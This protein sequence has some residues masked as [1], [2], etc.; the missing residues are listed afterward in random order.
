MVVAGGEGC[1]VSIKRWYAGLLH[2]RTPLFFP[3]SLP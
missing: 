1:G 2:T 3:I